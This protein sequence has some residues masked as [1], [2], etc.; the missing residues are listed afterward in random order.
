LVDDAGLE[1][2]ES[3][4]LSLWSAERKE[5]SEILFSHKEVQN[6]KSSFSEN[7]MG[8]EYHVKLNKPALDKYHISSSLWLSCLSITYLQV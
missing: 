3:S 4:C 8:L 7:W 1:L 2:I 5:E 6:L